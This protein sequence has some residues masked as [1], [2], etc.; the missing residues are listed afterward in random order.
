VNF[1]W[2]IRLARRDAAAC[3]PLRLRAGLEIGEAAESLWLRGPAG[4]MELELELRKLPAE[5]RGEWLPDGRLRPLES[6]IP[7]LTLPALRWEP[8]RS[9]L[10]VGLPA[11]AW[12]G[13]PGGPVPLWIVHSAEEEPA[14]VLR[15]DFESW[16]EFA[17]DAA[18]V[19]LQRLTFAV[20]AERRVLVR[21]T[22]LPP[23]PGERFVER[24]GIAVPAGF[25][26]QPAVSVDVIRQVLG[27][28][29]GGFVLWEHDNTVAR[30]HPEQFV[31]A[32]RRAVRATAEALRSP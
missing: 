8:I 26:W 21:G 1:P 22:P 20:S 17:Q 28:P 18:E 16:H 10:A 24:A 30:L 4:D 3:T 29:E 2:A 11:V 13:E 7:S 6:R 15:T 31:A 25:G 9:W 14:N 23:L 12:P 5:F 27:L 19:R 32:T